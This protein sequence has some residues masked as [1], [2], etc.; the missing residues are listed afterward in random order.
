MDG[1]DKQAQGESDFGSWKKDE[2]RAGDISLGRFRV[3]YAGDHIALY[4]YRISPKKSL[5]NSA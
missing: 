1:C 4:A 2:R 5:M 3:G